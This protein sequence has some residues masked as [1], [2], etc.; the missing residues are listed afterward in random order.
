VDSGLL[1]QRSWQA[2]GTDILIDRA[3]MF[4]EPRTVPHLIGDC[5]SH[6]FCSGRRNR[7][8]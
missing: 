3:A 5:F 8:F 7:P 4:C 2:L 6:A 1:S